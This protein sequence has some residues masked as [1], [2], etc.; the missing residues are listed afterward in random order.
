MGMAALSVGPGGHKAFMENPVALISGLTAILESDTGCK[1][2]LH[3]K[4]NGL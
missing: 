1:I 4:N 2:R 3:L